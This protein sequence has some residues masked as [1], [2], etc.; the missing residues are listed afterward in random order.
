MC[1][2]QEKKNKHYFFKNI[3]LKVKVRINIIYHNETSME[4]KRKNVVLFC[5]KCAV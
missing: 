4:E 1:D 2:K 3:R 5:T